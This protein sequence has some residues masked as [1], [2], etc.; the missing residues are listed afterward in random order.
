MIAEISIANCFRGP[1][2]PGNG[3]YCRGL[4]AEYL[5]SQKAEILYE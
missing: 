5:M 1:R 4:L 2:T 3:S